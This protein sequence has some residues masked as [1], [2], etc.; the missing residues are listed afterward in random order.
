MARE[1]RSV[2]PSGGR[3][4]LRL[5]I[6]A[7]TVIA[8][9]A[10]LAP[11]TASA[12]VT[13]TVAGTI[14][15]ISS[16]TADAI[17]I[18]RSGSAILVNEAPCGSATVTTIGTI[19]VSE[20]SGA[21]ANQDLVIDLSAGPLAPGSEG[22]TGTAEIGIAVDLGGGSDSL[23]V[24]GSG[25]PDVMTWGTSGVN[26]NGDDD[27]DVTVANV[28]GYA[29][30]QLDGLGGDDILSGQ[31]GPGSGSPLASNLT[32]RGGDGN[33]HLIG[34]DA[35]DVLRGGAG[36]DRLEG[37]GGEDTA[38]FAGA[39]TGVTA[40]LAAGTATG[41][42]AD[43][44][45][46]IENLTGSDFDDSLTGDS[47]PNLIRGGAGNDTIAGVDGDD[48]L[49]GEDGNDTVS[50]GPG[51]DLLAGGAGDDS[52]A[53]DGG[54][55]ALTYGDSTVGVTVNLAAGTGAGEGS[56][57]IATVEDLFGSELADTLTGDAG[58]N[59]I[60]GRAGNDTIAGGG[61]GDNLR[62]EEGNDVLAGGPGN[63]KMGGGPGN[64]RLAGGPGI[65]ALSGDEGNDVL[66]GDAGGDRLSGDLGDDRLVGGAGDDHLRGREGADRL[67][68]GTGN[69]RL[70]GGVGSDR[71]L[72]G[73]G[74]DRLLARDRTRD[75]VDGGAGRDSAQ[76]DRRLDKVRSIERLFA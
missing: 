44:L 63:D 46:E 76:V 59:F 75:V 55:D 64:D 27:A 48:N 8:L 1:L 30:L 56:D 54:V 15:T 18:K 70:E 43:T 53:G 36:D 29:R 71:L 35:D 45:A 17:T 26:V 13:C 21:S 16:D 5:G 14:M 25:G 39:L 22:E 38:S 3:S 31:G 42:G 34:G 12:A 41:E 4:R 6:L 49:Q 68:G 47:G 50:G 60:R 40:D 23:T 19:V 20:V 32:L 24:R 62:G 51:D 37:R 69:D 58:P 73:A 61:G 11:G 7:G 67:E 52:L 74:D 10:A 9:G 2:S 28:A 65:D 57:T 33:D 72:G 66:S